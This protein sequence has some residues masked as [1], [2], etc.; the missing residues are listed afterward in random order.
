MVQCTRTPKLF[1]FTLSLPATMTPAQVRMAVMEQYGLL[2]EA[3]REGGLLE[4]MK[5]QSTTQQ[6]QAKAA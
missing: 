2:L 3:L 5:G 1:K 6:E 4:R